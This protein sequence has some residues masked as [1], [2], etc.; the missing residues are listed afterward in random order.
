M[1]R[2][3]TILKGLSLCV[4]FAACVV[5]F[6]VPQTA[7]AATFTVINTNN[8]GAGSLRQALIDSNNNAGIDTV[9][10]NIPGGGTHLISPLAP[11]S[12]TDGSSL[13]TGM[14]GSNAVIID[15]CSQPGS[16]CSQFPLTLTVQVDG[17][18]LPTQSG[19]ATAIFNPSGVGS[20]VKGL[21]ITG[22]ITKNYS[23]FSQVRVAYNGQFV[24]TGGF[25]LQSNFI[26]INLD[27]T[28][29]G[30]NAGVGGCTNSAFSQNV[31]IGGPNP[32]QGNVI[33]SNKSYG[34]ASNNIF[35][36]T[37]PTTNNWIIEGNYF[38]LD[39]TGTLPR[40]NLNGGTGTGAGANIQI[41]CAYTNADTGMP[42]AIIRN[43]KIANG[44]YGIYA[45]RSSG[46]TIQGNEIKDSSTAGIFAAGAAATRAATAGPP[47]LSAVVQ[48]PF[49]IQANTIT[50]G[51]AGSKGVVAATDPTVP[52]RITI[53]QNSIYN[54]NSLGI[55]LGNN[56]VTAN[57]TKDPDA[58]PNTI[59]NFPVLTQTAAGTLVE[60][61]YNGLPNQAFTMDYYA[62]Q[63]ADPSGYG[64]GQIWIGSTSFTTDG[65]GNVT[66]GPTPTTGSADNVTFTTASLHGSA[67]DWLKISGGALPTGWSLAATATDVAGN[68]SEFSNAIA[69]SGN[70]ADSTGRTAF[71][72]YRKQGT[73]TWQT[74]PTQPLNFPSSYDQNLTGLTQDTTYEYQLVVNGPAGESAGSIGTFAT[75]A[76]SDND[77]VSNTIEDAAPNGGDANGDGIQDSVQMNVASFVNSITGKYAVLELDPSCQI[78]TASMQAES[79]DAVSDVSYDYPVGLMNFK[80]TCG[81]SIGFTSPVRQYYY[82]VQANFM[83]RKYNPSNQTY[84][85]IDG[86]AVESL[87]MG[88]QS[89]TKTSFDITDGGNLDA[90]GIVN[91]TISDPAGLAV[92]AARSTGGTLADTG[93]STGAFLI[94][95]L[96]MFGAATVL[97]VRKRSIE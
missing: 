95:A 53:R 17:A 79:S 9:T 93:Q 1:I 16:D 43:N 13:G 49:I 94:A 66:F 50:S 90:D 45:S 86:A 21:S 10:F 33:G 47:A 35:I 26:G 87:S 23:A 6:A 74:T 36:T 88:G 14:D 85:N 56:G 2:A 89:L 75:I 72:R 7:S 97:A 42:G 38:G 91:G 15:G 30:N 34:I 69:S 39:P 83:L 48:T 11:Y 70:A 81:G 25:T 77:G 76:D 41:S 65:D 40:P 27:G 80:T 28:A 32:G 37:A 58:G 62:S 44:A 52:S 12:S 22:G 96:S 54:N 82:G 20:T 61:S 31:R 59:I 92:P 78:N 24:C 57:D 51:S 71:F 55:D 63:T 8:S 19:T 3:K 73:T 84:F 68:T 4:V 18:S 67:L 60:G 5:T 46:V 64:E 29:N